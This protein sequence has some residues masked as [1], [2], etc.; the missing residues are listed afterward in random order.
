MVVVEIDELP[1]K[2]TWIG[3]LRE[4]IYDGH[5]NIVGFIERAKHKAYVKRGFRISPDELMYMESAD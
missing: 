4:P 1:K 3:C 2:I 5:R